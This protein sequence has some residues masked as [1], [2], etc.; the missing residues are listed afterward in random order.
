ML[1][2][3]TTSSSICITLRYYL[4]CYMLHYVTNSGS[5]CYITLL[6]LALY[7]TLRFHSCLNTILFLSSL[8]SDATELAVNVWHFIAVSWSGIDGKL[9]FQ[10][11]ALHTLV[12]SSFKSGHSIPHNPA[13]YYIGNV[14]QSFE[15]RVRETNYWNRALPESVLIAMSRGCQGLIGNAGLANFPA[16]LKGEKGL[17][18]Q[19]GGGERIILPGE[20]IEC[21]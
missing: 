5:I 11:N 2:Y 20:Y 4:W 19:F 17:V 15:G 16:F 9:A 12:S 10:G 3:V 18:K 6:P 13:H 1:H 14:N 21:I 7:A 8:P